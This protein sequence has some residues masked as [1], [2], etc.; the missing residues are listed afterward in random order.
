[1][2]DQTHLQ[3]WETMEPGLDC[4][5]YSPPNRLIQPQKSTVPLVLKVLYCLFIK[6]SG[7]QK[8]NMVHLFMFFADFEDVGML[9][10]PLKLDRKANMDE[11]GPNWLA[12][13]WGGKPPIHIG[14]V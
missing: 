14:I 11:H 7:A 9:S 10:I 5:E 3:R 1:M 12:G 8:T 13:G 4:P 2:A 6:T